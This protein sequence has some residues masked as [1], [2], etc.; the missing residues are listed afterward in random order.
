LKAIERLSPA[1]ILTSVIL[2]LG[3][4]LCTVSDLL[5]VSRMAAVSAMGISMALIGDL[6]IIPAVFSK[7]SPGILKKK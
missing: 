5:P 1:H 7:I 3:F 2:V 6:I 4:L